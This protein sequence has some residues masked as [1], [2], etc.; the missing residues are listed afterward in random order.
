[1]FYINGVDFLPRSGFVQQRHQDWTM[2]NQVVAER[3]LRALKHVATVIFL[4]RPAE[5]YIGHQG[6]EKIEVVWLPHE[7]LAAKYVRATHKQRMTLELKELH[8]SPAAHWPNANPATSE[9]YDFLDGAD[10][11]DMEYDPFVRRVLASDGQH[12]H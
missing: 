1:E 2:L 7:A 11:G 9:A 4:G 5:R 8:P 6:E 10:L 3:Q 12:G